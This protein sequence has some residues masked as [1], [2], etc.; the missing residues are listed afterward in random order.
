MLGAADDQPLGEVGEVAGRLVY[1]HHARSAALQHLE[2][3]Q[4]GVRVQLA[5]LHVDHAVQVGQEIERR[6]H[7]GEELRKAG[8]E[9]AE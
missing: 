2:V 3:R 9:A 1:Q 6:G 5:R 7:S 8:H 4:L